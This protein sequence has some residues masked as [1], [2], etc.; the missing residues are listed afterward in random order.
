MTRRKRLPLR[1]EET[2]WLEVADHKK[3]SH[4]LQNFLVLV[5]L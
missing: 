5:L 4:F 2:L 3:T 1:S